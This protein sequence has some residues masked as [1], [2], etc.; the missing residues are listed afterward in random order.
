MYFDYSG[1]GGWGWTGGHCV[2]GTPALDYQFFFAEGTT[3]AGFEEWLTLQNP[4]DFEITMNAAYL[5][6]TSTPVITQHKVPASSR[7]TIYIPDVV[8]M[9]QD[10]SI[11]L[12]CN[13]Q[14]LAERPMYF[15]YSG[16][17]GWGWTGGHCVIGAGEPET[18]WFFAEGYTGPNFEEWLCIQNPGGTDAHVTITYYPEGGA[19]I[20]TNHTV[21]FGTRYTVYVNQDAGPDL[22]ICT[23]LESDQP[24]IV[25]RPMYF[26]FWGVWDGGH[27]VVGFTP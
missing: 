6:R 13:Y 2:M 9:D 10:V 5:L 4:N 12:S 8:G 11:Y 23:K 24:I 17:G 21:R 7:A 14:F 20:T 3:I 26:N 22:N 18:E 27:D 16:M 19:P 15:S 1:T 25:E